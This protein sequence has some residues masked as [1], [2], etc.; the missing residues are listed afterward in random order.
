MSLH[1]KIMLYAMIMVTQ[2]AA[3]IA[4]ISWAIHGHGLHPV[5][6][7]AVVLALTVLTFDADQDQ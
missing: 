4:G 6:V 3:M 2:L 7:G 5:I 1:I